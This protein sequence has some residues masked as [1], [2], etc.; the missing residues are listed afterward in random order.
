MF[1][2]AHEKLIYTP[3]G[4]DLKF[5]PL[6]VERGLRIATGNR[7]SG[8]LSDWRAGTDG[9]GDIG[10]GAADENAVRSARAEGELVAAARTAFGLPPFPDCTDAV[11]LEYLCDYLEWMAGKG[12]RGSAPPASSTSGAE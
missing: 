11:V 7:L 10:A 2:A 9:L 1:F 4:T 8:L 3:T 12:T 5:D 6:A